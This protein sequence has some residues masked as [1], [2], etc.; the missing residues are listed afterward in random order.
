MSDAKPPFHYLA[1][2]SKI[3][4]ESFEMSELSKASMRRKE[5]IEVL[6]EWI[7][8]EVNSRLARWVLE[9]RRRDPDACF[10][11]IVEVGDAGAPA[12]SASLRRSASSAATPA[13]RPGGS[14]RES[15]LASREDSRNIPASNIVPPDNA[16]PN[17]AVPDNAAPNNAAPPPKMTSKR[18]NASRTISADFSSREREAPRAVA[19][20]LADSGAVAPPS[21]TPGVRF[22]PPPG[23]ASKSATS[24]DER[25]PAH[26]VPAVSSNDSAWTATADGASLLTLVSA[27]DLQPLTSANLIAPP[28]PQQPGLAL[29]AARYARGRARLR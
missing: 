29:F 9:H 11:A 16:A 28:P 21:A 18:A 13:R 24:S 19:V 6:D 2:C 23:R 8:A 3:S 26:R 12:G 22:S 17:N 20:A 10:D 5:A 7:E 4:L 1:T 25:P 27:G 15:A 14:T